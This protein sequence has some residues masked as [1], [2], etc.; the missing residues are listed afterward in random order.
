MTK[1]LIVSIPHHLGK[2]E[3][4]RRL[5]S[6]LGTV[7]TSYGH[8]LTVQEETWSGD[9]LLFR[10]SALAQAVSGTIDVFDD[11]VNLEVVL[12]WL[13]AAIAERIQPLIR[14]EATLMLE[15]K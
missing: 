6:G 3:A 2:E 4:V 5:K 8:L 1:P 12:P 11:R 10:V 15:K 7:R 13:L 14:H 9:R